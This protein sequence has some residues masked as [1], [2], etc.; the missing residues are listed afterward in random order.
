M[1]K[2][3]SHSLRHSFN[4]NHLGAWLPQV[5][6]NIHDFS[7]IPSIG[8][9]FRGRSH[10][11]EPVDSGNCGRQA[12]LQETQQKKFY[13]N[14]TVFYL[15]YSINGKR[16]WETLDVTNL[17]AALAARATKEAALLSAVSTAA[18]APAKRINADDAMA[19]YL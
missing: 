6:A 17:T 19:T 2:I 13:R 11:R 9:G 15:R 14:G 4:H 16:R 12:H 1:A 10:D 3:E 5:A 18:S 8:L 7:L